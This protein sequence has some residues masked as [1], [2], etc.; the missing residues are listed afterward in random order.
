[1]RD[2]RCADGRRVELRLQL[3]EPGGETAEDVRHCLAEVAEEFRLAEC[4]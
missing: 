4:R 2:A 1:V 3:S